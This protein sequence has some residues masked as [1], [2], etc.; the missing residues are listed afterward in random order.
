MYRTSAVYLAIGSLSCL[1][2]RETDESATLARLGIHECSE[3]VGDFILGLTKDRAPARVLL[4]DHG[5]GHG[6]MVALRALLFQQRDEALGVFDIRLARATGVARQTRVGHNAP[7]PRG[8][9][10]TGESHL[11]VRQ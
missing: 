2:R 8:V 11:P 9:R 5:F 7:A 6:G 3:A 1:Y 10:G 4:R